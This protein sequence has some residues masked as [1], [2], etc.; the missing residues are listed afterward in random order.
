MRRRVQKFLP[1]GRTV[2][3]QIKD[4]SVVPLLLLFLSS[5]VDFKACRPY[6]PEEEEV[7]EDKDEKE[8]K[9]ELAQ[10]EYEDASVFSVFFFC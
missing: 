1:D 10:L 8:D 3:V 7:A 5:L 9:E 6:H 2:H 4:G